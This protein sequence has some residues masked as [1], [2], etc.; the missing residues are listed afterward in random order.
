MK[1]F[2][3]ASWNVKHFKGQQARVQRVV[4]FLCDQEP[5]ILALYEVTGKEVFGSK[6][7]Q[8]I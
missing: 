6:P 1:A 5:D 7:E 2:S 8:P 3:V 4:Q